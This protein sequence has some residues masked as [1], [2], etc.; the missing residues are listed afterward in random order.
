MGAPNKHML[1]APVGIG[2]NNGKTTCG[3]FLNSFARPPNKVGIIKVVML[4][5]KRQASTYLH[6]QW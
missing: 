3:V 2:K 1:F 4:Y 5:P 6:E